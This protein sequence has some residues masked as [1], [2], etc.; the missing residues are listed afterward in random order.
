M[1]KGVSERLEGPRIPGMLEDEELLGNCWK[2]IGGM[3]LLTLTSRT[4]HFTDGHRQFPDASLVKE[5]IDDFTAL[6]Y[7]WNFMFARE[8]IVPKAKL[9]LQ[10][11]FD[12]G[13]DT[14]D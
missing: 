13:S 10:H 12:T 2:R 3:N 9:H 14:L 11:F 1:D 7:F 8:L 4:P 5:T 6:P